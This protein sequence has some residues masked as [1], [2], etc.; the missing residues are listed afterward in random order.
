MRTIKALWLRF[1]GVFVRRKAIEFDAELESHIAMDSDDSMRA[2]LSSEEAHRQAVLRL[3]GAEQTRQAY[4]DRATLP[5]V[6][7]I[8]QDVRFA[9]RQMRRA[10]GFTITAVLTLALGIG[11]NAV[12]Y[13][14]VD[15]ILLRPLPYAQQNRL[16]R[17]TGTTFVV[18]P[19]GWIR[20]LGEQSRAFSSIA[21]F[22]DDVESNV[23]GSDIPER[24][25]G[26]SVT[27]NAL[28]TL[29]VRSRIR[30]VLLARTTK[31]SARITT[32]FSATATAAP[33]LRRRSFG[34]RP[35]DA[36]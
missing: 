28:G 21:G 20:E 12:I 19:K 30:T 9:M 10:P 27:V 35:H 33:A 15:S 7:S 6:E 1:R 2:G 22:G 5:P 13:T 16:M 34:D 8:L 24:V 25:F 36:H 31:S 32:S 23:T 18:S 11:A 14:L 26:A 3:G 4:R 17:I 29:G